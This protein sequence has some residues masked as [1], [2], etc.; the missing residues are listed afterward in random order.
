MDNIPGS[1]GAKMSC[2]CA[3]RQMIMKC[4]YYS[5]KVMIRLPHRVYT[6]Y[7]LKNRYPFF[8]RLLP[9]AREH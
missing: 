7:A 9:L 1:S 2:M 8:P 4:L 3:Q 5:S 6:V